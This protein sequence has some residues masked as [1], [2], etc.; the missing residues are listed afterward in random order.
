MSSVLV[1]HIDS[2]ALLRH[3]QL[4]A[5]MHNHARTQFYNRPATITTPATGVPELLIL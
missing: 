4:P 5:G 1:F 3:M 2:K